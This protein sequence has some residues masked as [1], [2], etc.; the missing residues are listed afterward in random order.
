M[1]YN[2]TPHNYLV[3]MP[4]IRM[5]MVRRDIKFNEEKVMRLSL[6][7]ELELHENEDLLAPKVEGPQIDVEQTHVEVQRVETST[8]AESS[9]REESALE[10]LTNCWMMHGR[11]WENPLLNAGPERYTGYM[12]LMSR[13]VETTPS[14]FEEALQRPVW[15]DAMV[16]EYDSI[17]HNNFWDLIP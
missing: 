5:T 7:R 3:D 13:C 11:M 8:Q 15:V 1:G 12:A 17:V 6:E 2:G 9:E 16:E 10:R 4:T 14:S